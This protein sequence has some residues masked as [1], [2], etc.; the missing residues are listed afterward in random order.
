MT[1]NQANSAPTPHTAR[2]LS[3]VEALASLFFNI[4]PLIGVLVWH[5]SAF[6][7]VFLYWLENVAIGGRTVLSILSL[8][9]RGAGAPWLAK[10]GAAAFFL[11]H[12][13]LFCFVH[14][15]FVVAMFGDSAQASVNPSDLFGATAILLA[16]QF[17]MAMGL[18]AIVLWQLAEFLF[19][20]VRSRREAPSITALMKAPYLRIGI[21]HV[22]I[23]FGGFLLMMLG[24]PVIGVVALVV[25][26]TGYDW[27]WAGR[28]AR[29]R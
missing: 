4:I 23:I 12:Y 24:W 8:D 2:L 7:V 13:G 14:G 17:N 3:G 5:W 1:E 19:F 20:L 28:E 16:E 6:A 25:F 21:L 27:F 18:L 29:R 22:T 10:L 11:L 9:S 15:I 26:K